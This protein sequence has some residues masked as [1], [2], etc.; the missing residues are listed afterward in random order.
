MRKLS[1]AAVLALV[2]WPGFKC[3]A[4]SSGSTTLVLSVPTEARLDPDHIA[5]AF[6]VSQDGTADVTTMPAQIVARVRALPGQSVRITA[7]LAGLQG[8][9]GP[10]PATL[11]SWTGTATSASGNARQATCSNGVFGSGDPQDLVA[12]W[13]TSGILTCALNFQ[14]T[15]PRTLAP[16]AYSGVVSLAVAA[17]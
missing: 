13:Q 1:V 5:L 17:Q 10:A 2:V 14:L 16:G 8:P 6:R 11:V 3:A 12:G 4:Q 15:Q 7:L 9:S